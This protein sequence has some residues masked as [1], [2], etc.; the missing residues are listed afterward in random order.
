[1]RL[2]KMAFLAI[3]FLGIYSM[4]QAQNNITSSTANTEIDFENVYFQEWYAGI[5]V[6]GTGYNIYFPNV[7]L[8]ENV[9]LKEVY[10]RNLKAPLRQ[11][12]GQ[13]VATLENPSKLYTFETPEK[14]ADYKFN[15]RTN[16]CVISYIENGQTNY[17]K[18][19]INDERAGTYYENGPPSI[20]EN[21]ANSSLAT[22]DE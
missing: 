7:S 2:F 14:P 19:T 10:F 6:G 9:Q 5:K 22:V 4:A 1:M 18:I 12:K 17:T 3:T 16:E 11:E 20:Y 21:T 8:N 13:F 15:L